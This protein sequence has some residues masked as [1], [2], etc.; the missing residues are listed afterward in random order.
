MAVV[1]ICLITAAGGFRAGAGLQL[2]I[3]LAG[4]E[5]VLCGGGNQDVKNVDVAAVE[6]VFSLALVDGFKLRG[7]VPRL[8]LE[9]LLE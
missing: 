7:A 4:V 9:S 1:R 3:E 8:F 5:D 2:K 6:D